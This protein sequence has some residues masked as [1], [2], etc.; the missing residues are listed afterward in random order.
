MTT[1]DVHQDAS[2]RE[3]QQPSESPQSEK[4]Q[5]NNEQPAD[6]GPSAFSRFVRKHPIATAIIAGIL[7]AGIVWLWK[8]IESSVEQKRLIKAAN[9]QLQTNQDAALKL[10]AKPM[11][12]SIRAEWMRGNKEQVELMLVDVIKGSDLLYLHFLDMSGKV[13]VSTD[14]RLE[15]LPLEDAAVNAVLGTDTTLVLPRDKKAE[16]TVLVAPVMGYDS[17]LGTLVMGAALQRW[18]AVEEK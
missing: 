10:L 5:T 2:P 17:R 6:K 18:A 12:W 14:K 3:G 7:L 13:I 8:D 1:Q 4:P 9:E 11:V 16:S 15:G